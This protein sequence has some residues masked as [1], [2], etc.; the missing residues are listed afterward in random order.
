MKLLSLV[1]VSL[2]LALFFLLSPCYSQTLSVLA[3]VNDNESRLAPQIMG[4]LNN[5]LIGDFSYNYAI[6]KAFTAS[7][8]PI[9]ATKIT[10]PMNGTLTIAPTLGYLSSDVYQAIMFQALIRLTA[11]DKNIWGQVWELVNSLG[12]SGHSAFIRFQ[13]G[14]GI[15]QP[16]YYFWL[17]E[18]QFKK[19][20]VNGVSYGYGGMFQIYD[21]GQPR[22][23]N[24]GPLASLGGKK[25]E[26]RLCPTLNIGQEKNQ[27][28]KIYFYLDL[29]L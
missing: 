22:I 27:W 7:V 19:E 8:G 17:A 28:W 20:F 13:Y 12:L 6:S 23:I 29:Y 10:T 11:M 4:Q 1:S 5:Y 18:Y 25:L 21:Q 14:V 9:I 24:F 2:T 26:A 15:K 16:D 3:K